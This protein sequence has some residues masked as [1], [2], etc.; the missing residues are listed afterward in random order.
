MAQESRRAS[1]NATR[2]PPTLSVGSYAVLSYPPTG[3]IGV[4]KKFNALYRGIF[5]VTRC[6]SDLNYEIEAMD[7]P[8][9]RQVVHVD[10]LKPLLDRPKR[11]IPSIATPEVTPNPDTTDTKIIRRSGRSN[12]QKST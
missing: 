4:P 3:E 2:V 11:L 6:I 9:K 7:P 12:G 1:H 5:R 8:F 10:R